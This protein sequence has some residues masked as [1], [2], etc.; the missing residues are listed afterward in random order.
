MAAE[1]SGR[2]ELKAWSRRSVFVSKRRTKLST[3]EVQK[4]VMSAENCKSV[5]FFPWTPSMT[6]RQSPVSGFHTRSVRAPEGTRDVARVA[7]DGL[8][9]RV[10]VVV[11]I[12]QVELPDKDGRHVAHDVV[13][14]RQEA[15]V[16]Q[17]ETDAAHRRGVLPRVQ[18]LSRAYLP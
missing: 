10:R 8:Q 4:R 5:I 12:L 2:S 7:E 6:C 1:L 14:H 13:Q 3:H 11:Q 18:A 9:R 15:L 17:R 16:A